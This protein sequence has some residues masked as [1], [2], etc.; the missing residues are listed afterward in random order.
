MLIIVA[1]GIVQLANGK[2]DNFIDPFKGTS[3]NILAYASAF[4]GGMWSF[5][6]W[7]QLNF[8]VEELKDPIRDF[9]RAVWM[10]IPM[11]TIIYLFMN[12]AYFT[13]MTP[14]EIVANDAVAVTFAYRTLGASWAWLIPLGVVL[15]TFGAT[16]GT[17]FT[18]ARLTW[19]A[20]RRSHLPKFLSY[21]DVVRTSPSMALLFN[22]S[23]A[24]LMTIPDSS[25]FGTILD[26]FSFTQW[27]FYGLSCSAVLV[28]RWKEPFKS[29]HRP[30]RV[31]IIIPIIACLGSL[32]LVVAP[33]ID[34]PNLSWL[35]ITIF[36][37]S[38]LV[39]YIPFNV[40]GKKPRNFMR[41]LTL[42]IQL[43]MQV[44]PSEM[45]PDE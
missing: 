19:V 42:K 16:N 6:G 18:S 29:K 24:L 20:A 34:D 40:Y 21:V 39:F 44:A 38:G 41:W 25:K 12:V 43:G 45:M 30:Y 3:T 27:M 14:A 1:T 9:P 5:D 4:Y 7:N 17:V 31:P 28:F 22:S 35:Y 37:F 26:L 8:I 11:V 2:T 23:I 10:S 36:L 15:S 32:F 33:I 13:V